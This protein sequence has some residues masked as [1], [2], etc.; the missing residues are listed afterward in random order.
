MSSDDFHDDNKSGDFFAPLA[1]DAAA[2]SDFAAHQLWQS[3]QRCQPSP[4]T[5]AELQERIA[6]IRQ[7]FPQSG[8]ASTDGRAMTL[9]ESI[10]QWQQAY[11]RCQGVTPK[12][13]DEAL[14]YLHEGA[15]R[16]I[17]ALVALDYAVAIMQTKPEE[18]RK[19]F[20]SLWEQGHV[21]A[22]A[23]LGKDSLAHRIAANTQ[24]IALVDG[25]PEPN[26]VL[27]MM[28]SRLARLENETSPSEFHEA[29]KEAARLLR[30]PNCCL[31]P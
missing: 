1:R 26:P 23:A 27:T 25:L 4:K 14:R 16:G 7:A 19:R 20:E 9:E 29:E 2:G 28:R 15:D 17:N 8:G 24:A 13:Y 31:S 10:G 18:S 5:P 11:E 22:L 30:N 12:M 21:S 3:L 6:R